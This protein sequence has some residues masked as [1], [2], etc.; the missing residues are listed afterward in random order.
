[1]PATFTP[2]TDTT[3]YLANIAESL[4]NYTAYYAKHNEPAICDFYDA[5]HELIEGFA[6]DLSDAQLNINDMPDTAYII[7]TRSDHTHAIYA[8]THTD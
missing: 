8:V 3:P 4:S 2:I 7:I 1:M 6:G 5:D